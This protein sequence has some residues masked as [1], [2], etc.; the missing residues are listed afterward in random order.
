MD[1]IYIDD[2]EITSSDQDNSP[3]LILFE[4][5]P[6]YFS[7][8][9]DQEFLTSIIDI[10]GIADSKILYQAN[11][12]PFLMDG[13]LFING[14]EYT[15]GIAEL[16]AGTQVD[17]FIEATD[18]SANSNV[19]TT[20]TYSY[21]AGEHLL[22]DNEQ[23]DFVQSFGPAA[24]SNL[25]GC[26]VR[27]SLFGTDI[28]Y[29]LIRNYTD[30]NRPNNDMEFHIWA[31]NNGLPGADLITPFLVTPEANLTVT[32][33]MTRVDLSGYAAEL[34]NLSGDVFVGYTV[35]SGETWLVQTTPAV[36][37]RSYI[38]NGTTWA[39]NPDDD[40]HFRLVTSGAALSDFC[41][42]AN[43][44]SGLMGQGIG[45][46]QTSTIFDNTEATVDGTEPTDG[47]DCFFDA[48]LDNPLWFTFVGDG[49]AYEI[50]TVMCAGIGEY[51]E[52]TQIA[53]YQGSDCG[54]LT[55]VTCNDDGDYANGV[56]EAVVTVETEPG[57][58]YYM[59]VDGWQGSVGAFC[60]QFTQVAL[61]DC[62]DIAIG[63][64]ST[65]Q[66]IVCFGET[67]SI[68]LLPGTVI[69]L[70]GEL[71][72]FLWSVHS[73]DVTGSPDPFN[74]PSWIG[75]FGQVLSE[76]DIYTPQLVND[77]TQIPAGVYYFTPIVF[78]G[79]IDVDQTWQNVD[80]SNGCIITG[81]SVLVALAP[82]LPPLVS[83]VITVDETIGMMNGEAS[84][85]ATGGS[86]TYTY[87][88]SNGETTP[89]ITGLS[90]DLY[91]YHNRPNR[92]FGG[93]DYRNS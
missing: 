52:D 22:Y 75:N 17:Y 51:N 19:A 29:A 15:F 37:G 27:F 10:S 23:V 74:E 71:F 76:D 46:P 18:G 62:D 16:P 41:S 56:L 45:N 42:D 38:F 65:D 85:F 5:A 50:T 6:F 79:G 28:K 57:V 32:S 1:G 33:P 58:T 59:M 39:A 34:S 44:L 92:L 67:T 61:I 47:T 80:F 87:A 86:G 72:G 14:D 8:V 70:N 89:T 60:A 3:P 64:A 2:V 21:I 91:G 55:P 43:D 73:T 26:A 63:T 12:S 48:G 9:G 40:F 20:P 54:D 36:G 93:C 88:W 90:G 81:N 68:D 77:G 11:G 13:P 83:N 35:P 24:M 7:T 84:A 53:V 69:P 4:P 82:E 25:T 49:E 31:D 30:A 78:G 66:Q